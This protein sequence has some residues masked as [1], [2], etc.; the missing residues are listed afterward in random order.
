MPRLD[1]GWAQGDV[2]SG[3]L[4]AFPLSL[5]ERRGNSPGP[6]AEAAVHGAVSAHA[7]KYIDPALVIVAGHGC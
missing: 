1:S 4:E 7:R 6:D 2:R 3:T 5:P